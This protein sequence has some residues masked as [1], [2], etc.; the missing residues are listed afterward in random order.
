MNI[1]IGMIFKRAIVVIK[2][3]KS[4]MEGLKGERMEMSDLITYVGVLAVLPL[5]GM[6]I[7]SSLIGYSF[8]GVRLRLPLGD[9][10]IGGILG[11]IFTIVGV[12]ILGVLIDALAPS[13]SGKSN[14]IQALKLAACTITPGLLFGI[15]HIIPDLGILVALAGL[16]GLY[17]LY[18]GIPVMME[19]PKEKVIGYTVVVIILYIIVWA[20]ISWIPSLALPGGYRYI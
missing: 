9:S 14:R 1:N 17:I 6:I 19:A 4:T 11:Y 8:W 13:F 15:L 20:I 18:S 5:V 12:L 3:Q 2:S 7:G 16:Y 10:I